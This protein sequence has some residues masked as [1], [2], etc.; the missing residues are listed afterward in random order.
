MEKKQF[1]YKYKF[2]LEKKANA[3]LQMLTRNTEENRE[4]HLKKH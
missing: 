1:D 2:I 4:R 3:R